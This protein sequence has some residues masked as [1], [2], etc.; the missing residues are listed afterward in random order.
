M[1]DDLRRP[2]GVP[3]ADESPVAGPSRRRALESANERAQAARSSG[4]AESCAAFGCY[5]RVMTGPISCFSERDIERRARLTRVFARRKQRSSRRELLLLVHGIFVLAVG[6]V[7]V[8]ACKHAGRHST[9]LHYYSCGAAIRVPTIASFSDEDAVD[10][11][12]DAA[13]RLMFELR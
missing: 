11:A 4:D 5:R 7:C 2:A 8:V 13:D 10:R 3:E 6:L 9:S 1:I 12:L